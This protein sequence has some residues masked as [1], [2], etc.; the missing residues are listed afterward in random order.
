[1][2]QLTAHTSNGIVMK[3]EGLS[4]G[5]TFLMTGDGEVMSGVYTWE[6]VDQ[7]FETAILTEQE[8]ILIFIRNGLVE[9]IR[10]F[11]PHTQCRFINDDDNP[12]FWSQAEKA[13]SNA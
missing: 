8:P 5:Q 6:E 3:I 11:D 9:K 10:L 12:E 2:K 1:M 13:L 4:Q 7:N